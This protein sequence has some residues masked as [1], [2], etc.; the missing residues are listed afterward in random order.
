VIAKGNREEA[1][2]FRGLEGESE[3]WRELK[4]IP[5]EEALDNKHQSLN[6]Y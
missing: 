3:G 6:C 5:L 1:G 4:K 2:N